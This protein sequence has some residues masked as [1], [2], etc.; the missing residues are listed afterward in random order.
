[1]SDV[2]IVA[3]TQGGL[4]DLE[5][6][7][8]I[9]FAGESVNSVVFALGMY[10]AIVGSRMVYRSSDLEE[11]TPVFEIS[12]HELTCVL[13]TPDHL[14]LGTEEAHLYRVGLDGGQNTHPETSKRSE[15]EMLQGF[16]NAESRSEW[17]TPWGGPP[18]VRSF[19]CDGA[20]TVFVNVHVGGILRSDDWGE[21]FR[22]I[23]DINT[24]VHEVTYHPETSALFASTGRGF[25]VDSGNGWEMTCDG[26]HGC[27]M[28]A[29]A[30]ADGTLI[31]S[32]SNGPH[33]DKGAVYRRPVKSR[34]AFEKC[35]DGLPE[36]FGGNVDTAA[37]SAAG[38]VV[39]VGAPRG[40]VYVSTDA[41]TEWECVR[42]GLPSI[43]AVLA[44]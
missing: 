40:A 7:A 38:S 22:Q 8:P 31:A 2:R 16:E 19:A 25:A 21:T 36:W 9:A 44:E 6:S 13:P 11:W 35:T 42:S 26:L 39:A 20:S 41:G 32:A 34:G 29:V 23:I 17:F 15:G 27:Y 5:S 14:F 12:Q 28:R 33:G 37:V 10:W 30:V 18:A 24:D 4:F 3:A 1:M 43:H